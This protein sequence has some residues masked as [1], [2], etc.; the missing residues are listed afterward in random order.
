MSRLAIILHWLI[1]S[2]ALTTGGLAE[3]PS[4]YAVYVSFSAGRCVF[5][6]GDV[7]MDAKQFKADLK[8]RFDPKG[9]ILVYYSAGSPS[10]CSNKAKK[11]AGRVG[12]RH[13]QTEL[14]PS[15]FDFGPPR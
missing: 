10:T 15:N 12:F 8:D 13:V 14:A 4:T 2:S 1:V 6:T 11:I 5:Q 3:P 7:L 9:N